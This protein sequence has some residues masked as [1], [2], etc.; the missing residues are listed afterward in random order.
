MTQ[1]EYESLKIGDEIRLKGTMGFT[2]IVT[3]KSG[4]WHPK[5]I[6]VQRDSDIASCSTIEDGENWNLVKEAI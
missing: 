3:G 6:I 2:F 5:T 1:A 4:N